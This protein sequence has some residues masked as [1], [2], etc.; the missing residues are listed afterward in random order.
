VEYVSECRFNRAL[1][2]LLCLR[3]VEKSDGKV[4]R[5]TVYGLKFLES[6]VD[7]GF[8]LPSQREELGPGGERQK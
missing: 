5:V 2:G 6:K 8:A 4:Y 3:Y 7:F 1:K